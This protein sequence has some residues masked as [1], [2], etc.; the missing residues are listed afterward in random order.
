MVGFFYECGGIEKE[1]FSSFYSMFINTFRLTLGRFILRMPFLNEADT[2]S[3]STGSGNLIC[4]LN[5]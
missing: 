4:F 1:Y 5:A 2:F 3:G